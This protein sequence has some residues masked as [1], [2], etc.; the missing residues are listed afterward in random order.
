MI[1][2]KFAA[3]E[4][5]Y[6]LVIGDHCDDPAATVGFS[7]CRKRSWSGSRPIHFS[8]TKE[9]I[10]GWIAALILIAAF[11]RLCP[12]WL[13]IFMVYIILDSSLWCSDQ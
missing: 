1:L 13:G 3:L 2:S 6:I 11:V 7:A 8:K 12:V 9:F 5:F 4:F 10:T